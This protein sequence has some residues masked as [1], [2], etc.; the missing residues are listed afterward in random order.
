[1]PKPIWSGTISFGLVTVPVKLYSAVQSRQVR[2]HQL[3]ASDQV[4]IEQKRICP[5]EGQEVSYDEI[6][7]GFEI[8]PDRYVVIEPD[9]L[10]ALAPKSTRTID[11]QD[12][13]ELSEIDPIF[14]DHAYYLVPGEGGEKAY[15]LL[16]EAMSQAGKVAVARVVLR[17]KEHLVA[18]RPIGNVLGMTTM[19]FADEIVSVDHLEE[20]PE[21]DVELTS[22]ERDIAQQLVQS[23]SVPFD[24]SKYHDTYRQAVLD[25]IERKAE[26]KEIAQQPQPAPALTAP[27][28]MSALQASLDQVRE[29]S[30]G[31]AKPPR[32]TRTRP[33]PAKGSGGDSQRGKSQKKKG[34]TR[35]PTTQ[36]SAR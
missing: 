36:N 22:R 8:A 18:I 16:L 1:M 9:E 7:K 24:A 19:N 15:R 5:V 25:L 21:Q 26:G 30:D 4:R 17:S 32:K 20:L 28:L 23:L 14:Y 33:S 35:T 2:F 13:V 3:H 31:K 34:A 12:F 6:V 10:S 29:Q 11:I 27:D